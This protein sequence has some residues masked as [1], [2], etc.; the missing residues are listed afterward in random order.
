M[1]KK[2]IKRLCDVLLVLSALPFVFLIMVIVSPLI[3]A[4]DGFPV[5]YNADRIGKNGKLFKMYK[6]RSMKK[7]PRILGLPMVQH[8]MEK[9]IQGL[10]N[11]ASFYVP[12]VLMRYRNC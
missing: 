4:D 6:F 12:Q 7:T 3:I 9:M 10:R 2:Y 5:F 11:L 8:I 1:Y